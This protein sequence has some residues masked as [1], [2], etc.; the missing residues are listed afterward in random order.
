MMR[1]HRLKLTRDNLTTAF[2]LVLV[3]VTLF[4]IMDLESGFNLSN[5]YL[6]LPEYDANTIKGMHHQSSQNQKSK[7]TSGPSKN[8]FG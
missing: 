6:P 2:G 4:L 3:F 8:R 5:D 7:L 1:F